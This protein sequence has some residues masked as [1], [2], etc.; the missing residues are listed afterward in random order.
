VLITRPR[1]EWLKI[2]VEA[3][4]P[5]GPVNRV[6]QASSDPELI[7]R[8]LFYADRENG[9]RVPQVGL[10]IGV[11]GTASSY[12]LPPPRLGEHTDEVLREWVGYDDGVINELRDQKV[13]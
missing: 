10:G 9:R 5:A 3:K 8:G 1:D 13:V 6:D 2:F 12:R 11:D 7:A 4:V